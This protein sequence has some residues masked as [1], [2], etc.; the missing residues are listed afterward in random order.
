[1][2]RMPLQRNHLEYE[3]P[4]ESQGI[5]KTNHWNPLEFNEVFQHP[6]ETSAHPLASQGNYFET[7]GNPLES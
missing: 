2:N 5:A 1:M 7:P 3:S 6:S 4:L